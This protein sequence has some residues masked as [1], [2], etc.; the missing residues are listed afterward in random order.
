MRAHTL[1]GDVAASVLSDI[2][3]AVINGSD[4]CVFCFG[5]AQLGKCSALCALFLSAGLGPP[6]TPL[7]IIA[8]L[9]SDDYLI[10]V[11]FPCHLRAGKTT[12]M[13]GSCSE[14]VGPGLMPTAIAWLFRGIGEQKNKTG[15]RFSVR[16]SAVEIAGPTEVLRDLLAPHATG[17]FLIAAARRF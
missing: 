12:T 4:G 7:A 6:A 10:V 15:A 16:V 14:D 1:Q 13:V 8:F 2:V 5:H 11:S 17:K 9:M 3:T